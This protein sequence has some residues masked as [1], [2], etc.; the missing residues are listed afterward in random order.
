MKTFLSKTYGKEAI[1]TE[2]TDTAL[3]VTAKDTQTAWAV[4]HGAVANAGRYGIVK[5]QTEGLSWEPSPF[6]INKWQTDPTA[7]EKLVVI[8]FFTETE[9]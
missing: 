6:Q 1:S 3:L 9:G 5:V 4:A 2:T 7:K 8:T